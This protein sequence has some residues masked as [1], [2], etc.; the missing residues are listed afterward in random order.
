MAKKHLGIDALFANTKVPTATFEAGTRTLKLDDITP[1]PA[2]PRR[3]ID[4]TALGYLVESI[5]Q[6]GVLQPIIVREKKAENGLQ[7]SGARYEIVAGERRWRAARL[8]GLSEIPVTIRQLSDQEVMQIALVENLQREDLNPVEETEGYL[9][10]IKVRLSQEAE[11]QNFSK[12]TDSDP[13]SDVLRLLFAMNNQRTSERK[14]RTNVANPALTKLIPIVEEVFSSIGRTSWLSFIQHRL[15]LRKLPS[16]L[17]EAMRQ[18]KLEYTKAR[19]LGKLTSDNLVCD[20]ESA[21]SVRNSFL[22]KIFKDSLSVGELRH[23]VEK[24][25]S[26]SQEKNLLE[27]EIGQHDEKQLDDQLNEKLREAIVQTIE[28]LDHLPVEE[29]S[30]GQRQKLLKKVEE[31]LRIVKL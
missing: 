27:S 2:Q 26:T 21:G 3:Y 20:E 17:L 25:I 14:G 5:K 24:E 11:F 19:L 12:T 23:L 7:S 28:K 16:D 22:Q 30:I 6:S 4:E 31:I 1:N 10:L 13:Y 9:A 8:A 18:G 29:L 15:P